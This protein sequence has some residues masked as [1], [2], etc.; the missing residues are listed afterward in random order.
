MRPVQHFT[1]DYLEHCRKIS[2]EEIVEFLEGFRLLHARRQPSRLISMKVPEPLL[3]TF[4]ARC[5]AE[6]V[7]YQ[8]R[9]KELMRAWLTG[10]A[11]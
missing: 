7:R 9:I 1:D 11:P 8:T 5:R 10:D 6:G 4:K 2:A 3:A